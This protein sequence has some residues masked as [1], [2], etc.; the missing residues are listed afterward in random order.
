MR[1]GL[2]SRERDLLVRKG[3]MLKEESDVRNYTSDLCEEDVDV[4][5]TGS[6][7]EDFCEDARNTVDSLLNFRISFGEL[8]A[9][10]LYRT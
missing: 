7:L 8:S 6:T 5:G 9:K 4:N 2:S 3:Q 1:I 10:P